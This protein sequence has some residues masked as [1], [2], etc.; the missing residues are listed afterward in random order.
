MTVRLI[1][2]CDNFARP[3]GQ[4]AADGKVEDFV[5]DGVGRTQER[6]AGVRRVRRGAE[7]G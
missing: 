6:A 4:R 5:G 2:L 1:V 3:A 7:G